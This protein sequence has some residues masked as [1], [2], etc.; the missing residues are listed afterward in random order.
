MTKYVLLLVLLFIPKLYNAQRIDNLAFEGA[1]IRGLAY[2]GAIQAL[3][4]QNKLQHVKRIAG[5][6]AGAITAL[7]ISIGYNGTEIEQIISSTNFAKFNDGGFP[8]LGGIRHLRKNY[9]WYKGKKFELWLGKLI[10]AKT[11]NAQINFAQIAQQYKALYI[12][13]TS[14]NAQK[15]I[16]FSAENY[17]NMPV[18]NAVR[19][20]MSIPLYYNA[21]LMDEQGNIYKKAPKNIPYH[22][23]I[24]GGFIQNFPISVFDSTKYFNNNTTNSAAPNPYTI[25]FRVDSEQQINIDNT[26]T[27]HTLA[28]KDITNIGNYLNAFLVL[29]TERLNRQQLEPHHWLRTISISDGGIS[30]QIKALPIAQKNTLILNGF[31]ATK[32]YLSK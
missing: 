32:F 20:S 26:D 11:G 17:P 13:G 12:T 16:T 15:G 1:G 25:G 7:L 31:A 29:L 28:K 10:T 22:I 3:E 4:Q 21:V 6:S 9:G 2:C 18:L 8:I 14:L 30:P 5:T 19:I 24:D 23:M 27:T